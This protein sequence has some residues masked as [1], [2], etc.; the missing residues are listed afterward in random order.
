AK[1]YPCS[2]GVRLRQLGTAHPVHAALSDI[3]EM[4]CYLTTTAPLTNGSAVDVQITAEGAEI[5][6]RGVIRTT[7]SGVGS[8]IEFTQMTAT[9]RR[10]LDACL[11]KLREKH[12]EG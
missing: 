7:H 12:S 2:L 5:L 4:G 1:R 3:S 10:Q 11:A 6:V 9:A 8:G